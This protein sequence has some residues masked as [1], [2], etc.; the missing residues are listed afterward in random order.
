MSLFDADYLARCEQLAL[1]SRAHFGG[2]LLGQRP[3]RQLAG[4]TEATGYSDYT[5][6]DDFRYVDWSQCA[7]HDELLSKQFRGDEDIHAYVMLDCSRSMGMGDKWDF[8][9]RLTGAM[10]YVAMANLNQVGI[11]AFA[12]EVVADFVPT[13]GKYNARRV[14]RFLESLQLHGDDTNL[15]AMAETVV[16]RQQRPGLAVV[17]SDLCDPR[18]F[19]RGLDILRRAEYQ[20]HVVQLFDPG[21]IGTDLLGDVELL[22]FEPAARRQHVVMDEK[23]QKKYRQLF[24]EFLRNILRYC[25]DYSLGCTQTTTAMPFD[26]RLI[27]M[28]HCAALTNR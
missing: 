21:E 5:A 18:G 24:D 6:G 1:M 12:D 26:R 10:T 3:A 27:H 22:H 16:R 17:V 13:R 19:R 8:A 25:H 20:V 11:T 9:R 14:M 23:K 15:S 4:G 28:T 2:R 7:R